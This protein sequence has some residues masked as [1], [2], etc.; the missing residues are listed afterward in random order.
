MCDVCCRLRPETLG[1]KDI[2]S[3]EDV[4]IDPATS[5]ITQTTSWDQPGPAQTASQLS[6]D[7]VQVK[8]EDSDLDIEGFEDD[9]IW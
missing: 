6:Q 5:E 3:Y 2:E 1:E 4:A 8:A 9:I 7:T